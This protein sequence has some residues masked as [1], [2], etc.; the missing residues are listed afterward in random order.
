[1]SSR[2][3]TKARHLL[4]ALLIRHG[5]EATDVAQEVVE[6]GV[7]GR[8]DADF[9]ERAEDVLQHLGESLH[10]VVRFR[11]GV[12]PREL[13]AE[14]VVRRRHAVD[15][16]PVRELRPLVLLVSRDAQ[17][18]LR[19][20]VLVPLQPHK[21]LLDHLQMEAHSVHSPP[22]PTRPTRAAALRCCHPPTLLTRILQSGERHRPQMPIEDDACS[23]EP[24]HKYPTTKKILLPLARHLEEGRGT[25]ILELLRQA[26]CISR[27]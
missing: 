20:G 23:M 6:D 11:H 21:C 24:D 13:N 1:M 2:R 15:V 5:V 3:G 7:R 19:E 10:V 14:L 26:N 16:L 12:H 18:V 25:T 17:P 22:V 9:P 8:V 4:N 27:L